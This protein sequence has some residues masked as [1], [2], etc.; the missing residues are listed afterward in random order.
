[1]GIKV[2]KIHYILWCRIGNYT[3]IVVSLLTLH[4]G[5]DKIIGMWELHKKKPM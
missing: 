5:S 4:S 3:Y 1:M 2:Y